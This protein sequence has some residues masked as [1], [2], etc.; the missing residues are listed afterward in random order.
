MLEKDFNLYYF[1][2]YDFDDNI[3]Y[4]LDN[5]YELN[6]FLPNYRIRDLRFRLNHCT[7]DF[8]VI[9]KHMHLFKLYKFFD[10]DTF[11]NCS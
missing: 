5:L 6:K 7:N 9:K 10:Y 4:N 11:L 3:I 2:V 1:V 8:L